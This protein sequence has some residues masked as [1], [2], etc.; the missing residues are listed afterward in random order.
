MINM[1]FIGAGFVAMGLFFSSLTK[2]QIIAAVLTFCGMIFFLL[3]VLFYQ[4][5]SLPDLLRRIFTRL[6]FW[7]TLSESIQGL[8]YIRDLVIHASLTIF[9]LFLTVKSVESRKWS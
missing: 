3:M 9:W 8:I 7:V 4:V 5:P 1:T 6:A 2:N